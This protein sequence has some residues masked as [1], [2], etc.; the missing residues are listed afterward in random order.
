MSMIRI[1]GVHGPVRSGFNIKIQ[2][3]R[4]ILFFVNVTR[5]EPVLFGS[6]RFFS[7]KNQKNRNQLNKRK[8]GRITLKKILAENFE[9]EPFG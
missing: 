5:T 6:G 4:K 8:L 9:F 2:P 3:N 1:R 7:L